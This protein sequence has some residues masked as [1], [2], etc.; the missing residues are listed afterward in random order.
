LTLEE[1]GR[2]RAAIFLREVSVDVLRQIP[3]SILFWDARFPETRLSYV[4]DETGHQ[5]PTEA[6]SA[7]WAKVISWFNVRASSLIA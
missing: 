3:R 1:V 7:E 6:D 5:S 4:L 2:N